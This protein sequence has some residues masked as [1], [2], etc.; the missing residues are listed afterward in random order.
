[1]APTS[2]TR[3]DGDGHAVSTTDANGHTSLSAYDPLGRAVVQTNPISG[4]TIMTYSATEV[5]QQRDPQG[6][7]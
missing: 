1:M 6:N 4:T 5:Q 7:V 3:Y 2:S